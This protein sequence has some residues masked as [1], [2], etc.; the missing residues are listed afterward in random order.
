MR[1]ENDHYIT[2]GSWHG[3]RKGDLDDFTRYS[4]RSGTGSGKTSYSEPAKKKKDD[5]DIPLPI[6]A[7]GILVSFLE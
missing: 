1:Y 6:L 4:D 7:L 2:P 3:G 5:D